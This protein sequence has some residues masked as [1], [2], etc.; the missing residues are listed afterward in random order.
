MS[1]KW[2]MSSWCD[3]GSHGWCAN[4]SPEESHCTCPCHAEKQQKHDLANLERLVK[5]YP[6]EARRFVHGLVDELGEHSTNEF[7]VVTSPIRPAAHIIEGVTIEEAY[8]KAKLLCPSRHFIYVH[9]L[10]NSGVDDRVI[11]IG[12]QKE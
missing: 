3:Q 2:G 12:G 5:K 8:E 1:N 11:S 7:L 6:H 10:A 9:V 4:R